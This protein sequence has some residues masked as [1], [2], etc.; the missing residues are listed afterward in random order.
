[1]DDLTKLLYPH[2]TVR[3]DAGRAVQAVD[4]PIEVGAMLPAESWSW[5]QRT[6]GKLSVR[7]FMRL[8]SIHTTGGTTSII[9]N[10]KRP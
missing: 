1:M 3:L 8:G 5:L 6:V 4:N 7:P 9:I 2:S 10:Q